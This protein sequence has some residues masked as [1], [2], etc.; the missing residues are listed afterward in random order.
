MKPGIGSKLWLFTAA[1]FIFVFVNI[2]LALLALICFT[3][4]VYF[5]L[6]AI[7]RNRG[8]CPI[9]REPAF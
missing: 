4:P 5:L 3:L 9:V 2:H 8:A 1:Y 6:R 7:R